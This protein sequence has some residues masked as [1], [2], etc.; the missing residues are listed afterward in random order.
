MI[1]SGPSYQ[2]FLLRRTDTGSATV[3]VSV[4]VDVEFDLVD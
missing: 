2:N 1:D 4:T 3:S